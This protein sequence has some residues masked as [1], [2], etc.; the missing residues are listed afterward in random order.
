MRI[1]FYAEPLLVATSGM[2]GRGMLYELVKQSPEYEFVVVF[3]KGSTQ[4]TYYKQITGRLKNYNN[5]SVYIEKI[6]R[7]YTN[8]LGLL[9]LPWYNSI[10]V[11]GDVYINGDC[12]PMGFATPSIAV[13]ADLSVFHGKEQSS[14]N[15]GILHS[16]RKYQITRGLKKAQKVVCISRGTADEVE[17]FF[18]EYSDKTVVVYNGI[19]DEWFKPGM[20]ENGNYWI[21]WGRISARKNLY[22]L[23]SAYVKY[24][25]K[26][27]TAPDLL[28][29]INNLDEWQKLK[30]RFNQND[31][32]KIRVLGSQNIDELVQLVHNSTG[33]VFPSFVE[34]FGLPVV[35][36]LACGKQILTSNT[37]ILK[38]VSGG[39]CIY[40]D[41]ANVDS[42]EE[43]LRQLA[44]DRNTDLRVTEKRVEWAKQFTYSSAA[45]NLK[46]II[47]SIIKY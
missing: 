18:P 12:T 34:G 44:E 15:S 20:S 6:S 30:A 13:L 9:R 31:L 47:H 45:A 14:H 36:G 3:R 32:S 11:K 22:N 43:G 26:T 39:M 33:V 38:E 7:R 10:T 5:C 17:T 21:W 42:I 2:P 23:I 37:A 8:L 41:P 46:K 24:T 27:D 40:I 28:L 29:V 4:N 35:E 16:F 25:S 1:I 19:G